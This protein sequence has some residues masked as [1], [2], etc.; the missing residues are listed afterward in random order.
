VRRVHLN[1]KGLFLNYVGL[2]RR[3]REQIERRCP[4]TWQRY[5]IICERTQ[6]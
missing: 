4:N 5:Q 6:N 1:G 2:F 3:L